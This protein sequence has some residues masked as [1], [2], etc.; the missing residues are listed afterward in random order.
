LNLVNT[1][2]DNDIKEVSDMLEAKEESKQPEN[3]PE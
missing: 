2:D 1:L 3:V